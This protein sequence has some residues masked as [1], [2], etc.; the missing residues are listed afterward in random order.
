MKCLLTINIQ[1]F[2]CTLI[3]FQV[4]N[5]AVLNSSSLPTLMFFVCMDLALLNRLFQGRNP[6]LHCKIQSGVRVI[7]VFNN[8]N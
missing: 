4:V 1:R 5:Q 7:E 3:K 2:L 8:R 6:I